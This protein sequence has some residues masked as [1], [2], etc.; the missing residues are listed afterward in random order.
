MNTLKETYTLAT[1]DVD[2]RKCCKAASFMCRTQEIANTHASQIGFGYDQLL[3]TNSIWVLSRMKVKYIE[4]P[5]WR[6]TVDLTTWHKGSESIFALRDFELKDHDSGNSLIR[7]TSSW[8]VL[9]AVSRKMLRPDRH[10]GDSYRN[11]ILTQN[12]LEDSCGKLS[13]P[14]DM[15][16]VRSKEVLYSD[17]D[18]NKHTNNAKYV[19]W[20]F[21]CIPSEIATKQDIDWYQIN[22][23][24]ETVLGDIV[25]LYMATTDECIYF[26]EGRTDDKTIFQ[27]YIQFKH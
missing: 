27:F 9:D 23:N 25:N 22:F 20:A 17:V 13:G 18:F 12:A 4:Q 10:F 21:D 26:V 3:A 14:E 11:T 19:E 15:R 16:F 8:L 2:C 5:V 24:H 7:A 1:S 6:Q